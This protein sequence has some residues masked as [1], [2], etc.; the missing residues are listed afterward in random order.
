[1]D[2][3]PGSLGQNARIFNGPDGYQYR[4]R[5]ANNTYNDYVVSGYFLL[6]ARGRTPHAPPARCGGQ[7]RWYSENARLIDHLLSFRTIMAK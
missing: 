6:G 3:S 2:S 5:P 1:M 7:E 4:W